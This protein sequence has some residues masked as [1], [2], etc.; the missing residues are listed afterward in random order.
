MAKTKDKEES[1][2]RPTPVARDGPY[3]MM[4]FITLVAI[5]GGCVLMQLDHDEYGK[6]AAPK[7]KAPE[8]QK[9]G[10]ASKIDPGTPP[11]TPGPGPGP[12]PGPGPMPPGPPP[13]P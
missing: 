12:D 3:V 2:S 4:L 5:I 7:E 11:P 9:L 10:S 1:P 8:I 6:T 13:M